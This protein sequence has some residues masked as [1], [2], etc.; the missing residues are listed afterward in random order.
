MGQCTSVSQ[1]KKLQAFNENY[2][3][4]KDINDERY[5]EGKLLKDKATDTYVFQKDFFYYSMTEY[6][7]F[8]KESK[9][10]VDADHP[11]LVK[12]AGYEAN[13]QEM[14]CAD[15]CGV[16]FFLE[17]YELDLAK[18]IHKRAERQD[19]YEE[20]EL[21]YMLENLVA[22]GAFLESNN[23]PVG[24]IRP[25][26]VW[27]TPSTEYKLIDQGVFRSQMTKGAT[28][29][30]SAEARSHYWA[31]D[32][33]T[34]LRT[35]ESKTQATYKADV[36]TLGMTIVEAANLEGLGKCY[37]WDDYRFDETILREA[38][39]RLRYSYTPKFVDIIEK[40]LLLNT[41]ARPSF[42]QLNRMLEPERRDIKARKRRQMEKK[43]PTQREQ[44]KSHGIT[45]A[46]KQAVNT[47]VAPQQVHPSMQD[48][49]GRIKRAVDT[50]ENTLAKS[51]PDKYQK[52]AYEQ[53]LPRYLENPQYHQTFVPFD[54]TPQPQQYSAFSTTVQYQNYQPSSHTVE[55]VKSSGIPTHTTPT[56]QVTGGG[57][58]YYQ[59]ATG[60]FRFY[61]VDYTQPSQPVQHTTQHQQ[62][63]YE[64]PQYQGQYQGDLKY[65]ENPQY[66]AASEWTQPHQTHLPNL[67]T[68]YA[69]EGR[70]AEST[71]VPLTSDRILTT[72]S[73]PNV[74]GKL[75]GQ[76]PV[77][78]GYQQYDFNQQGGYQSHPQNAGG[79]TL[80][81]D[82]ANMKH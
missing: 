59:T 19:P 58:E 68:Q 6:Q 51:S 41:E 64:T 79:L 57:R 31:P 33:F 77:A 39:A 37:N 72:G 48:L 63:Y 62:V 27:I 46:P 56:Q 49:D 53:E 43:A 12:F 26:N 47:V 66:M 3:Y 35:A 21:W 1:E 45:P 34:G 61:D 80:N 70:Y 75:M 67:Q 71:Y 76:S 17:I 4:I 30:H 42:V 7:R 65:L 36:F 28:W 25:L 10:R 2:V 60:E 5:Q 15:I 40:A 32:V 22:A 24:D 81:F 82:Y 20:S 54:A 69:Q 73:F 9:L 23:I 44:P 74:S 78:T 13:L 8:I 16:T 52:I 29:L 18:D 14:F 55:H 38:V 50:T 11:N